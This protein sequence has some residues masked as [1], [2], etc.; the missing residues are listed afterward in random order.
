MVKMG[1]AAVLISSFLFFSTSLVFGQVTNDFGVWIAGS[2]NKDITRDM[3]VS[4]EQ[5]LRFAENATELD[6]AYTTLAID[7]ELKEWLRLGLNYRFILNKGGDG[8]FGQRNRL[9]ADVAVRL[10]RQRFTFTNRLRLQSEVRTINYADKYGFAPATDLRN[11]FKINY[12][13]NRKYEPYLALDA[14]FLLR[15]ARTPYYTG[16]DRHRVTAG[17]DILLARKRVLDVYLMTSRHWNVLEPSHLF[18][19]G[20]DFT[21]GSEGFLLGS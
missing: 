4:I 16:F 3:D 15:D 7:Y 8:T 19:I 13:V 1:K 14:R 18:V 20:M 21:F 12:K 9:M 5:E 17:V 6:K 10:R 11:T 2:F